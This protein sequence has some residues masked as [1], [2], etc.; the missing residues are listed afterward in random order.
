MGVPRAACPAPGYHVL[1]P[2]P[3]AA[4][5]TLCQMSLVGPALAVPGRAP[6]PSRVSC[7]K[8][9]GLDHSGSCPAPRAHPSGWFLPCRFL[10]FWGFGAAGEGGG[11]GRGA[12]AGGGWGRGARAGVTG[13][14]L[15]PSARMSAGQCLQHPWLNNLA[16][17]AK[18][19]NRRLKSQVL[20]KKYVMRRRWK[21]R[22]RQGGGGQHRL[23]ELVWG[24]LS[25]QMASG[26]WRMAPS[27]CAA[28]SRDT[29]A[30][31]PEPGGRAPQHQGPCMGAPK[32]APPSSIGPFMV[33]S[34]E[35]L[36]ITPF[37]G[38][39]GARAV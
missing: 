5:D 22:G 1:P 31:D 17:K 23:G 20:L 9:D 33:A 19:C 28:G 37:G 25:W 11:W 12:R 35:P 34:P 14:P 36:P 29:R 4:P 38:R 26:T 16:E 2:G 6:S 18:R 24:G 32:V 3:A 7:P 30:G 8:Q 21:V 10:G 39:S 27:R 15:A 13:A